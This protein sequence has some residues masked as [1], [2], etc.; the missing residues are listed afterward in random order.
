MM[1]NTIEHLFVCLLAICMSAQE[2]CL[3]R[4]S[5]HFSFRLFGVLLL[6]FVSC[7]YILNINPLLVILFANIF[8][9][10]VGCLFVLFMVSFAIQRLL[11][12]TRSHLFI[13]VMRKCSNFI[14]LHVV[15]QFPWYYILKRLFSTAYSCLLCQ[16]LTD[17]KGMT[18]FV[19]SLFCSIDL[20]L[21]HFSHV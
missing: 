11:T 18:L 9:H 4:S 21:S 13:F 10:S 19:G 20:L 5:D 3:F 7:L 15:L 17:H 6:I 8:R 16:R 1:I 12:L 2:K 14:L